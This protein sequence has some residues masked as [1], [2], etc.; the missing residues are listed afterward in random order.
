MQL[1]S[2]QIVLLDPEDEAALHNGAGQWR[3][4]T[5]KGLRRISRS[6]SH[7][8]RSTTEPLTSYLLGRAPIGLVWHHENGDPLDYRRDN[9]RLRRRG[10]G[11][12][13]AG[14][15]RLRQHAQARHRQQ[16]GK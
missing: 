2:G 16:G 7:Q 11:I 8:G 1:N 3:L 14:K 13:P 4:T 5:F 6:I 15:A 12:T 9:L 10:S